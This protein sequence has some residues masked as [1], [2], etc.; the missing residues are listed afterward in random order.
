MTIFYHAATS[1]FYDTRV[2]GERTLLVADPAWQAPLIRIADPDWRQPD[3]DPQAQPLLI[4]VPDPQAQPPLIQVVNPDC[5]LPP[6]AELVELSQAQ[7]TELFEA[8]SL[9]KIIAPG[10]DGRPV[11]VEPPPLTWAQITAGHIKAVQA[12][13]DQIAK[14]AGYDGIKEAISYADEPAVPRFQ[15]EGLAFRAWRS[16]VWAYCYAA[17]DAAQA[18]DRTLPT[19]AELIEELPKLELPNA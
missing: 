10:E 8:Q 6:I 18:G 3:D 19:T 16:L 11:I 2:H 13:L 1:G 7:Y 9:G 14:Q 5:C 15:A 17:L 4:E 12:H